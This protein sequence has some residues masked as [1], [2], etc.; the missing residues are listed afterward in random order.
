MSRPSGAVRRISLKGGFTLIEAIITIVII[1]ALSAI[2]FSFIADSADIFTIAS[3]DAAVYGELWVAMEKIARDMETADPAQI[4]VGSPTSITIVNPKKAT[5]AACVDK[6]T[7]I[8][9][10]LTGTVLS[11]T[12]TATVALADGISIPAGKTALF[13][14]TGNLITIQMT[15]TKGDISTTLATKVYPNMDLEEDII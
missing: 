2:G 6:A 14:K 7:T 12:G 10:A 4:T 9:Y 11:R 1:S 15:K 5:C 8:T 13:V 3:D